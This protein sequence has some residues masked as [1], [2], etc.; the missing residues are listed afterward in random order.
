[1][2]QSVPQRKPSQTTGTTTSSPAS[3]L[4]GVVYLSSRSKQKEADALAAW[5]NDNFSK[6]KS[7]RTNKQTQWY[8]NL[9][10]IFGRQWVNTMPGDVRSSGIPFLQ[11]QRSPYYRKQRVINRL[12]SIQRTEHSKFL[13]SIPNINVIP[14]TAEDTDLRAALAGEQVWQSV[15][16]AQN[17]RSEF[18]NAAW[19]MTTT[20]TGIIKTQWNKYKTDE[21]S[22]Q[23][24]C[25]E[26]GSITPFHLFVPDLRE[27]RIE[28]QPYVTQAMVKPISWARQQFGDLVAKIEPTT[29]SASSILD[30]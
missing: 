23:Q 11:Q 26:Y 12:R 7:A 20:G 1:M 19:W 28:D 18:S 22:G 25:I 14:S 24:G 4:T 5:V 21:V 16:S 9:S 6:A 17:L 13:Q 30:E 3:D 29:A 15:S 10:F 27:R 8:E 2:V